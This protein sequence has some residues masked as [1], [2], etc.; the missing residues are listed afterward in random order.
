MTLFP[1]STTSSGSAPQTKKHTSS[2]VPSTWSRESRT[3][4]S[5]AFTRSAPVA[6]A[7]RNRAIQLPPFVD[8]QADTPMS[9]VWSYSCTP[10]RFKRE[11]PADR[12]VPARSG[13]GQAVRAASV[14]PG[15]FPRPRAFARG[16]IGAGYGRH[17]P[18][19]TPRSVL[20]DVDVRG[21]QEQVL[22]G[23]TVGVEQLVPVGGHDRLGETQRSQ[24][25]VGHAFLYQEWDT[26]PQVEGGCLLP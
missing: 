2:A 21:E 24:T 26:G 12:P 9:T 23:I 6:S 10:F 3:A 15:C 11:P 22:G 20:E 25:R 5:A 8:Y 13:R 1:A 19:S 18:T 7:S 4:R 14:L 17:G 16:C